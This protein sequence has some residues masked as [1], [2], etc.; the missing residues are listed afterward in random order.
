MRRR[1]ERLNA[2]ISRALRRTGPTL[3]LCVITSGRPEQVRRLLEAWRPHVDEVF[4]A[5]DERGPHDT[6]AQAVGGLADRVAIVPAMT[7]M[8]RYLGWAHW[9]CTSDWILRVDDDEL[10]SRA[11]VEALP[12]L[13]AE[14]ELTHW[15]LPR[16]WVYPS[17]GESIAEG[18]WERDIQIRIVRNQP[19]IWRF[20]GGMHSNIRVEGA[21]RVVDAPLLHLVL[22]LGDVERRRAKADAYE[23]AHPGITDDT[24]RP[25]QPRVR[26]G[27]RGGGHARAD[28]PS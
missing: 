21:G 13:L 5:L 22:L 6:I 8:E 23:R 7:W 16:R 15:W 2:K 20:P 27:G 17:P 19:G 4:L 11:L 24:G 9:Q 28:A 1:L 14:R 26:P 12:S 3:S 25:H 10:P 18:L